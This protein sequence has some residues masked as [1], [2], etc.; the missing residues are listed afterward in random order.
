M[1]FLEAENSRALV[2]ELWLRRRRS[3]V[4][5]VYVVYHRRESRRDDEI[6]TVKGDRQDGSSVRIVRT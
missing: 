3:R 5:W 2:R 4:P 6:A 1:R